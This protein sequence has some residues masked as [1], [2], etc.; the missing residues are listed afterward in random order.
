MDEHQIKAAFQLAANETIPPMALGHIGEWWFRKGVAA[1][2]AAKGIQTGAL[3]TR[4]PCGR[5][6]AIHAPH[7]NTLCPL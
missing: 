1:A 7:Q 6:G 2:L 3:A 4:Q 5:C